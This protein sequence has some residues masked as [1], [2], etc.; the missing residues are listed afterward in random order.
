MSNHE[1]LNKKRERGAVLDQ[2]LDNILKITDKLVIICTH[3]KKTITSFPKILL[4]NEQ[5][6]N[7]Y[8]LNCWFEYYLETNQQGIYKNEE[9]VIFNKMNINLFNLNWTLNEEFLLL[10]SIEKN[11][12]DNWEDIS[13]LILT[14]T[15]EECEAHY[16]SFYYR[17]KN[18]YIPLD[19]DLIYLNKDKEKFN[20]ELE[21]EKIKIIKL[22]SG[23]IPEISN[24]KNSKINEKGIEH[25]EK[26][27]KNEKLN[28][29]YNLEGYWHKRKEF[30]IEYENDIEKEI[31]DIEFFEDDTK[32][33]LKIKEEILTMYNNILNE[34]ERRK[35]FVIERKIIDIKQ[36][37][38]FENRLNKEEREI[39][40]CLKPFMRFL[41]ENEF[42][43]LFDNLIIEKKLKE[44]INELKG[45]QNQGLKTYEEVEKKI[46]NTMKLHKKYHKKESNLNNMIS[47]TC[48]IGSNIK[49][50]II[51]CPDEIQDTKEIE[52]NFLK[53]INM[54]K[55]TFKIIK[56]QIA[57]SV[58]EERN[59]HQIDKINLLG[60]N[61]IR[62]LD[63]S[64]DYFIQYFPTEKNINNEQNKN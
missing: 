26:K 27:I 12:F 56:K 44:R 32:E 50:F 23:K 55:E 52:E 2:E 62:C 43:E 20:E 53:K 29:P 9:Y 22:N 21:K 64:I 14:K 35:N 11:G 31:A 5:F 19:D 8:C 28:F 1:Y 17:A 6:K 40:N 59:I 15:K 24:L 42:Q 39:Y 63:E 30:E 45:Y 18:C 7:V 48:G 25:R 10:N 16:N 13:D 4:S 38:N 34:R 33:E 49:K 46:E 47:E 36:Q 37:N 41:S 61:N 57:Q 3:C 60:D 51:N 58:I 54:N